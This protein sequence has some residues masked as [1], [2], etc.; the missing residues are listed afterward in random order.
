MMVIT[1]IIK[2]HKLDIV[3]IFVVMSL[4]GTFVTVGGDNMA[5]ATKNKFNL[6]EQVVDQEQNNNQDAQCVSGEAPFFSC[7]NL[8]LQFQNNDGIVAAGQK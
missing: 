3:S 8:S 1:N 4:I 2:I 7:N 5:F 6:A